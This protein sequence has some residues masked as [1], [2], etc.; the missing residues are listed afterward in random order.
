MKLLITSTDLDDLERV[1]KRL[2]WNRI[3]C[4]VCK[5]PGSPHLS[6]W[7]HNEAK[8]SRVEIRVASV[9]IGARVVA[10]AVLQRQ[11]VSS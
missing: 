11:A 7:I 9:S 2:V 6:V 1:V 8:N 10:Q 4:A 5:D 3:P